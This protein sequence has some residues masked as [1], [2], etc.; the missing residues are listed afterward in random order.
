MASKVNYVSLGDSIATGTI[1]PFLH[2]FSYVFYIQKKFRENG[3]KV[4]VYNLACDGDTSQD[5]LWKINNS[6]MFRKTI[7]NADFITISIGGNN[8]IRASSIPGFTRINVYKANYGVRSF[9]N[10][11]PQII[12]KIKSINNK[13]EI[14]VLNLY[15]PYNHSQYL[16]RNYY[17]D[18]N[19]CEL[20]DKFLIQINNA[21]ADNSINNYMI[22]DIY[23]AFKHFSKGNMYRVSC[24]YQGSPLLRNPHPTPEG[25]K[26]IA[27]LISKKF[28]L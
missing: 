26:I 23:S 17:Y 2:I 16:G 18:R 21:I 13:A 25:Q 27:D 10:N 5:L 7:K 14:V 1:T 22:A 20:T 11:W 12:D 8:L 3:Y 19:L 4:D 28:Y 9:I 15:N 24:L 6:Y